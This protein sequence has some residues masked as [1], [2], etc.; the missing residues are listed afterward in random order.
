MDFANQVLEY[1]RDNLILRQFVNWLS[2]GATEKILAML[3]DDFCAEAVE[4][5]NRNFI[6]VLTDN[7]AKSLA[8]IRGAAFSKRQA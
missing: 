4:R 3:I 8:H 2:V 7:L 5:V 6:R 1:S